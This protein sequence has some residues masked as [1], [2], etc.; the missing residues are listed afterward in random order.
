MIRLRLFIARFWRSARTEELWQSQH[1]G[2]GQFRISIVHGD[3][4]LSRCYV[5]RFVRGEARVVS[6]M[7]TLFEAVELADR[8]AAEDKRQCVYHRDLQLDFGSEQWARNTRG[9]KAG[10]RL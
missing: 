2:N 5:W 6:E 8:L 9:R 7:F 10:S 1:S 4:P 3:A